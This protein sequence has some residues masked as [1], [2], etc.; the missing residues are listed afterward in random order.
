MR[1]DISFKSHGKTCRGWLYKP[2]IAGKSPAIVMSHGLSGV[3]E[4]GLSGFAER[5]AWRASP[6]WY[7]ITAFRMRA[8][9]RRYADP[10]CAGPRGF[11]AGRRAEE[12]G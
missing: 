2:D 12:A 5:F 9:A 3:K 7:L 1:A 10:H 8:T 11:R 6:L 4:Q